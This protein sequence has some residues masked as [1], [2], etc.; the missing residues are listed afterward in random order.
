M[1]VAVV[2]S[3]PAG[4]YAAQALLNHPALHAHVDMLERLP[5]PYGLVRGGV[6]P[7]HQKIKRV[8]GVYQRIATHPRFRLFANV[9]VGQAVQPSELRQIYD[10]VIYA[11]GNEA[12]RRM[13]VPGES[14]WACTPASVFVGWYNAHPDYAA[15]VFNLKATKRVAV[16]GNGNV[17]I[18]VARVLAL[19]E[20]ELQ[21]TDVADYAFEQLR[22]SAVEEIYVIGRR[23]PLQAA[24]TPQEL[25]ELMTL[26]AGQPIVAPT[27]L[28]LGDSAD[29]QYQSASEQARR[30]YEILKEIAFTP[31]QPG[32]RKIHL[33]FRRSPT[34]VH[35]DENDWVSS[36]TLRLN[37]LQID[38]SGYVRAEGTTEFE[39]LEVDLVIPAIGYAGQPIS[40]LPFDE[41]RG[42]IRNL[43]GRIVDEAEQPTGEYVVGWARSGPKGLIGAHKAA[44]GQVVELLVDDF[45]NLPASTIDSNALPNLL[46]KR[47]VP[48]VTFE[49]W[50]I[51]DEAEVHRARIRS[52]ECPRIKVAD[53]DQM[54][55][56]MG[57]TP[58]ES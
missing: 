42:V 33:L 51:L 17:A 54:L 58:T 2:G 18:D 22:T 35:G 41:Q 45:K 5:T 7:D 4:F 27:E 12:S 13:G 34:R 14:L 28:E 24:F 30:V 43:D 10:T 44:S 11:V 32:K 48:F 47:A 57:K 19:T 50:Q 38:D 55:G 56:M 25:R 29:K 23:G 52:G 21:Q 40:G 9:S 31:H 15:A 6:A 46:T 49:D 36:L 37:R 53:V 39:E 16:I 1:H 26:E 3:G 20:N 8:T